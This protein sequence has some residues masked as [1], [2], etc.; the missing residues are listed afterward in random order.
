MG[1]M[2]SKLFRISPTLAVTFNVPFCVLHIYSRINIMKNH[3][4]HSHQSLAIC[5]QKAIFAQTSPFQPG[6]DLA[7][8]R[9]Q[10]TTD[11]QVYAFVRFL[12]ESGLCTLPDKCE[13][14]SSVLSS[15]NFF[16]TLQTTSLTTLIVIGSA[17][18]FLIS[19]SI[20]AVPCYSQ[21]SVDQAPKIR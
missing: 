4:N 10:T 20:P 14:Q 3:S 7:M 6:T 11:T 18:M 16:P 2:L 15:G 1:R 19:I 8:G 17:K 13:N 21:A 5:M 9:E 12:A